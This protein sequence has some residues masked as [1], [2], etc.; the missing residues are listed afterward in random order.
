[1]WGWG[2]NS[3]GQLGDDTTTGRPFAVQTIGLTDVTAVDA[4]SRHTVALKSDGTAWA[5]GYNFYGQL[6]ATAA[7]PLANCRSPYR[8]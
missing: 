3:D 4:G 7:P 5:W 8:G 6:G 1:M 2:T